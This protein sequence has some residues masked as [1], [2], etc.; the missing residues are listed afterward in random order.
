MAVK[1]PENILSQIDY[2]KIK[3]PIGFFKTLFHFHDQ[4]SEHC[5]PA[6]VKRYD[7]ATG[8]ATVLPLVQYVCDT[9]KGLKSFDRPEYNVR[10]QKICHGGFVIDIPLFVGDTGWLIAGDRHADNAISSNSSLLVKDADIDDEG[11]PIKNTENKGPVPPDDN[12]LSSFAWGL[13]IPDFWGNSPIVGREGIVIKHIP[14]DESGSGGFEIVA[15]KD[16]IS[17]ERKTSDGEKT[18]KIILNDDGLKYEGE[19]DRK[20]IVVTNI[21]YDPSSHQ[22]QKKTVEQKIRGDFVVGSGEE[23]DWTMIDG[24]Q[25][26]PESNE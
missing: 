25:A 19:E 10:V 17:V 14:S 15:N 23:S 11:Y 20:Q 22:I 3:T 13:F 9:P 4:K 1:P 7:R 8:I 21:R 5:I 24:G 26:V 18:D 16:S 2:G 12:S 6:M